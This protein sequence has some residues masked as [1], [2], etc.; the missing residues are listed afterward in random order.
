MHSDL[1]DRLDHVRHQHLTGLTESDQFPSMQ[2][3]NAVASKG[4]IEIVNRHSH[5][6][7]LA[8]HPVDDRYL[9]S[10]VQMIGWLIQQEDLW[11]CAATHLDA[12]AT[13]GLGVPMF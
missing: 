4:V 11:R 10:D 2:Y 13:G 8:D 3:R 12:R 1:K 6:R 9:V 7:F 5:C